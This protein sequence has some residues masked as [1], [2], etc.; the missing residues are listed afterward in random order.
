M[1]SQDQK[2]DFEVFDFNVAHTQR[3]VRPREVKRHLKATTFN[4][5]MQRLSGLRQ[6]A[7]RIWSQLLMKANELFGKPARP[8]VASSPGAASQSRH[9]EAKPLHT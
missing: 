9:D 1:F 2:Q 3:G 7:V 6:L 8:F 4:V 5:F